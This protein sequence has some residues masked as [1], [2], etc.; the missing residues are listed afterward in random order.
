MN[1]RGAYLLVLVWISVSAVAGETTTLSTMTNRPSTQPVILGRDTPEGAMNVYEQALARGDVATVADAWNS[2]EARNES[3]AKLLILQDRIERALAAHLSAAELEK[4]RSE[5][6]IS[7]RPVTRSFV[8]DDWEHPQADIVYPKRPSAMMMQRGEDSIWRFGRISRAAH[9]RTPAR[10][11]DIQERQQK[12]LEERK[13]QFEPVIANLEADKYATAD[14]VISALYP[15]GSPMAKMHKFEA[16]E[17]AEESKREEA[18]KQ[19]LLAAHFDPATLE[20]AIGAFLQASVKHDRAGLERFY[21]ADGDSKGRL[22]KA[23]ARRVLTGFELEDAVKKQFGADAGEVFEG[24]FVLM[25]DA[26]E[27]FPPEDVKGDTAAGVSPGNT[28][29][30]Y[31]KVGGIWKEDI[32]TS[33]PAANRAEKMEQATAGVEKIVA[34]VRAGKYKTAKEV[35]RAMKMAEVEESYHQLEGEAM[36]SSLAPTPK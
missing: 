18:E 16:Q 5:C 25:W 20:G 17:K 8:A 29:L 9:A 10:F 7:V 34:D 11:A 1:L 31:R 4:I 15:E 26:P 19:Q 28:K 24:M 22:A 6:R 36:D 12:D 33:V 13:K 27:W 21:Y 2:A 3:A 32:T 23:N 30:H 35:E 14:Q